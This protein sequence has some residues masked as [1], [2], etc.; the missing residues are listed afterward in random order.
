MKNFRSVLPSLDDPNSL[1]ATF[2]EMAITH[3]YGTPRYEESFISRC[4]VY[5]T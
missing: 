2:K 5:G 3:W 4:N 1:G